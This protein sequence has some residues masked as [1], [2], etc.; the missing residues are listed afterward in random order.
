MEPSQKRNLVGDFVDRI[1]RV[2]SLEELNQAFDAVMQ[3]L[4]FNRYAYQLIKNENYKKDDPLI[5]AT[6][7]EEWVRY[8]IDQS[9][10][11]LD[12]VIIQGPKK[13]IPFTWSSLWE[14][15]ELDKKQKKFFQEAEEFSI[16]TGLGFPIHGPD[17]SFAMI[18]MAAANDDADGVA[19]I[20]QEH[21]DTLHILS[22]YYHQT[23]CA[24]I[25]KNDNNTGVTQDTTPCVQLTPRQTEILKWAGEHKSNGDIADILSISQSC[26]DFHLKKIKEKM[27]VFSKQEAVVKAIMLKLIK[28]E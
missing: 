6:Y 25:A 4:H 10:Q 11:K 1:R 26:V 19:K 17:N 12:P 13:L 3:R 5:V 28:F 20:F 2:K 23:L 18:S 14:G 8:Y 24:I 21:E 22:L 16:A 7:P 27:G 9:Y 15:L